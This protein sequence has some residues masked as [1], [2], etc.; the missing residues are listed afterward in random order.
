LCPPTSAGLLHPLGVRRT[1][2]GQ[3]GRNGLLLPRA[4]F[5]AA[6][7]SATHASS[8]A[9]IAWCMVSGSDPSTKYGF[10]PVPRE[11]ASSSSWGTGAQIVGLL[12]LYPFRCRIGRT[13]PSRTGLRNL[14]M[15]QLVASGPVSDSPSP[16]TA[17]TISSGLSNAAPQACERQYPSSPPSW[18]EPGV[19]GVP[20][21]S[22][23]PGKENCL[24]SCCIPSSSSL[25]SG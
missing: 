12:I 13:A 24:K 3:C 7:I 6:R 22:I 25:Q 17:A 10:H 18:I 8:V 20:W 21:L 4:C 14:L 23:P 2:I 16:T 1:I 5:W 15:C 19:S 11:N 9:A